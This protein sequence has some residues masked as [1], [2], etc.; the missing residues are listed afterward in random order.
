[1]SSPVAVGDRRDGEIE[2]T[3]EQKKYDRNGRGA[4]PDG[5]VIHSYNHF[6]RNGHEALAG[7]FCKR[8]LYCPVHALLGKG[9]RLRC[10]KAEGN[11]N[12]EPPAFT[13]QYSQKAVDRL[14]LKQGIPAL[15]SPSP[16]EPLAS[17]LISD[18]HYVSYFIN[19]VLF[20]KQGIEFFLS[21]ARANR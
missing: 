12:G 2:I 10:S 8:K 1:M 6:H 4:A 13:H 21:A 17:R 5:F 19:S 11:G 7:L 18:D 3:I 20:S 14:K 9:G 16:T 15:A